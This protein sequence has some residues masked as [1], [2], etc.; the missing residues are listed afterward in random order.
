MVPR[1]LG[2][3]SSASVVRVG[4][5]LVLSTGGERLDHEARRRLVL[6]RKACKPLAR[7][8]R[9]ATVAAP[10]E[11]SIRALDAV[12]DTRWSVL[13]NVLRE[14]ARL[15]PSVPLGAEAEA[16]LATYF[17]RGLAFL[18]LPAQLQLQHGRALLRALDAA[19]LSPSLR[20][21]VAPVLDEIRARQVAYAHALD[22]KLVRVVP[23]RR[24]GA[25]RKNALAALVAFVAYVAVMART[26]D[27]EA[28][29]ARI[30]A[31]LDAL[32]GAAPPRR[33]RPR[34]TPIRARSTHSGSG[35]D[36]RISRAE[37]TPAGSEIAREGPAPEAA[38]VGSRAAAPTPE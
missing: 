15:G 14:L 30:L 36:P 32:L 17:P 10:A 34:A 21:I 23:E 38:T 29:A 25:L 28:R 3:L 6:L 13:R 4:E 20:A 24:R 35:R 26:A 33:P 9:E 8:L 7:E 22:T 31:P 12:I 19:E 5:G 37:S 16:T 18:D 11:V 2:R 27:E 1:K